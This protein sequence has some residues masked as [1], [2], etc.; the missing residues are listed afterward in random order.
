MANVFEDKLY[1]FDDCSLFH[2]MTIEVYPAF[3]KYFKGKKI[4]IHERNKLIMTNLLKCLK[5]NNIKP[6]RFK[7]INNFEKNSLNVAEDII[8]SHGNMS[9]RLRD[10]FLQQ[11]MLKVLSFSD[12]LD[13]DFETIYK[14]ENAKDIKQFFKDNEK[15]LKKPNNIP[16]KDDCQILKGLIEFKTD[17]DKIL[18]SDDEHFWGYSDEIEKEYQIE[19]LE[20]AKSKFLYT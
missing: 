17:K 7:P 16:E 13:A 3:R 14:V 8:R 19:I 2:L 6:H 9:G 20:E 12:E 10:Q 5:N 15:E 18:I 1:S 11:V 4:L